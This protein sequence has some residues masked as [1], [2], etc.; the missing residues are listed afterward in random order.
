MISKYNLEKVS[1]FV[2]IISF[3]VFYYFT[4]DVEN[5]ISNLFDL[6]SASCIVESA[7]IQKGNVSVSG[8]FPWL[9]KETTIKGNFFP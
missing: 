5:F 1:P 7:S 9:Q 3:S 2:H 8:G 6:C 4:T